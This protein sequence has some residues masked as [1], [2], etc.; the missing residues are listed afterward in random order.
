MR[1]KAKENM[2][3]YGS[4]GGKKYSPKEGVIQMDEPFLKDKKIDVQKN[5]SS[6][7]LELAQVHILVVRLSWTP[8]TKN[9]SSKCSQERLL[10]M[11]LIY[12]VS[13]SELE[14]FF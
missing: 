13:N 6:S 7:K 14:K 4:L 11:L 5:P 3:E 8:T 12:M 2:K 10:L 1:D 9:L